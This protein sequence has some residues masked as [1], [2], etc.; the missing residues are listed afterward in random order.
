MIFAKQL[1]F[2][3]IIM[4]N[5]LLETGV[6]KNEYGIVNL[7]EKTGIGTHWVAYRKRNQIV[8]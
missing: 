4:R 7:D 2:R 8:T 1:N 6:Y 3:G 5:G